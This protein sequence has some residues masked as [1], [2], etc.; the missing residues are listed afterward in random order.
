MAAATDV[1]DISGSLTKIPRTIK[2]K[3]NV[4]PSKIV[5]GIRFI[6]CDFELGMR[7]DRFSGKM[8]CT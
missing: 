4:M 8:A 7:L 5:K 1:C 6:H 2:N 3:S